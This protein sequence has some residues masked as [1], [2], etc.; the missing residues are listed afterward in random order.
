MA[1]ISK[2]LQIPSALIL[3]KSDHTIII[4][5]PHRSTTYVD[6]TYSYRPSSVI[7]RSACHTSEPCKNGCTDRA[8]AWVGPGNHVLDGVQIPPWEGANFWGRMGVPL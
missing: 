1:N 5:R 8:A 6:A 2:P 4:I 3:I 7:C